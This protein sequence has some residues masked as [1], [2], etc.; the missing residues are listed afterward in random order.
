MASQLATTSSELV[1]DFD[2][3]ISTQRD[4]VWEVEELRVTDLQRVDEDICVFEITFR[5]FEGNG[6]LGKLEGF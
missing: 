4:E 5:I 2:L 6:C 3:A 1:D